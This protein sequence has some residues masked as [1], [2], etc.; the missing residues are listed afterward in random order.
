[1]FQGGDVLKLEV[2]RDSVHA[3]DDISSH[4]ISISV[5][6]D[7]SIEDLLVKASKK[8][9]LP[10]ISGGKATWFAYSDAEPKQYLG[11]IAQQWQSPK[12]LSSG[13]VGSIFT[14]QSAKLVFRYWCQADPDQVFF[15]LANNKELPGMFA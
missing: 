13:T 14:E 4:A 1:M 6:E 3:G 2:D 9:T 8:C 5:H 11:V 15:A 10:T 12:V 7:M